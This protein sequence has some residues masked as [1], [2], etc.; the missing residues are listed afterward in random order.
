MTQDYTEHLL[1]TDTKP[2]QV[3]YA[4]GSTRAS[5]RQDKRQ[6]L[7][8]FITHVNTPKRKRYGKPAPVKPNLLRTLLSLFV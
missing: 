7:L 3:H 2:L 4:E 1:Q 6:L 8:T 5:R